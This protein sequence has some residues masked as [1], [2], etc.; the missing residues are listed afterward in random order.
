AVMVFGRETDM[1]DVVS[2][3]AA[4]FRRETCGQCVPCRVGVVRQEE[5]LTRLLD[6]DGE[7]GE[8]LRELDRVMTD[9]SICGLG[10]TAASAIRS[11]LDLGLVGRAR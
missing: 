6:G 4:F 9:A 5:A 8:R 2:R 11:A 1:G 7:A 10:Q 3:I